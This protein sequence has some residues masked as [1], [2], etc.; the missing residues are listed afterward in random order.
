MRG[1]L[2]GLALTATIAAEAIAQTGAVIITSK[3]SVVETADRLEAAVKS[4]PGFVVFERINYQSMAASQGGKVR[5]IQLVLF[6]RGAALQSL[7]TA[8]PTLG[9]DLPLKV[10]IWEAEDGVVRLI[11]NTAEFLKGRHSVE[12]IDAVLKQIVQRTATFAKKSAD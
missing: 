10:L 12:G 7:L 5:P 1:L 3:Y 8:A 6:G 11:Y 9:L 4:E 2:F